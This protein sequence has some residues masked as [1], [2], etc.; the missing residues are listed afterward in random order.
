MTC[1]ILRCWR[2]YS[3]MR[4]TCTSKIADG[5]TMT[6]V[7]CSMRPA[8]R[9]LVRVFDLAPLGAEIRVVDQR[10]ELAQLV[11]IAD[12]ALA[13]A[14]RDA[15]CE[16]RIGQHH[17]APRRHAVG[18]VAELLRPQ[19]GEVVEHVALEQLGV[20][21][22]HAVDGMTADAREVRHAHVALAG[23]VD[24][25]QARDALLVAEERH[26]HLI[27]VTRVDLVDD[28]ED[29]RQQPAEHGQRPALERLGQ[30]RVIGVR[31]RSGA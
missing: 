28:L 7:R 8:Q 13:D 9:R 11:Q 3:W 18:L 19:L 30:Q 12:P 10:L 21:R 5:S 25:R 4:F 1:R 16:A 14:L 23:F 2:L 27:E 20:Q 29:A 15:V 6:P 26:A 31:S 24:E 17:P 22:R